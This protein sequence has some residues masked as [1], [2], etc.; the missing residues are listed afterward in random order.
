MSG[1]HTLKT[2]LF[3]FIAWVAGM[4]SF[5]CNLASVESG[6]ILEKGIQ[7]YDSHQYE[8]ALATF[9]DA[10]NRDPNNDQAMY[11]MGLIDLYY[12]DYDQARQKFEQAIGLNNMPVYWFNLGMSQQ[13]MAKSQFDAGQFEESEAT[14][15]KC[16]YSMSQAVEIDPWYDEAWLEMAH[17]H[18]GAREYNDAA[19][20]FRKSIEANPVY[21][22]ADGVTVNYKELGE[23]YAKFGFYKEANKVLTNGLMNNPG[24]GQME[25]SLADVLFAQ[26]SLDEAA[27][28]YKG[29]QKTLIL[30]DPSKQKALNALFG[31]GCVYYEMARQK[32]LEYGDFNSLLQNENDTTQVLDNLN[33][34]RKWFELYSDAAITDAEKVRRSDAL[35]KMKS[36]DRYIAYKNEKAESAEN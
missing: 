28:H 16:V 25:T 8:Q 24:D 12:R 11:Y 31:A 13:G 23:L 35:H 30:R 22:D 14:Y 33:E 3:L 20:A 34:S 5:G 36:I 4:A 7:Q 18:L 10:V 19:E 29:A 15:L 9:Q 1:L 6:H 21:E 17:C 27:A 32:I 26:N 2:G